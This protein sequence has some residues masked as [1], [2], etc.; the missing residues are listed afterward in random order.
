MVRKHRLFKKEVVG[1]L[2]AGPYLQAVPHPVH[3]V[4]LESKQM[5]DTVKHPRQLRISQRPVKARHRELC[6]GKVQK[7]AQ[8]DVPIQYSGGHRAEKKTLGT[9]CQNP[10]WRL[11]LN[12]WVFGWI[13][14]WEVLSSLLWQRV[15]QSPAVDGGTKRMGQPHCYHLLEALQ[16]HKRHSPLKKFQLTRRLWSSA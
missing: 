8:S 11:N 2:G 4:C 14:Y 6:R 7:R 1:R 5:G 3:S 16:F 13:C 10:S 9:H 12:L 15:W